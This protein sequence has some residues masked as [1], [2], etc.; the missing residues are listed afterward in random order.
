M[1]ELVLEIMNKKGY[2]PMTIDELYAILN[3]STPEEFTSLAKT[4]NLLVDENLITYNSK[5]EFAPLAYFQMASGIIEVKEAGYAFLDTDEG[6]IYIA[7]NDLKGAITY[8]EVMVKYHLN[9]KKRFEGKVTRIIKRNTQ[10]L[11]GIVCKKHH[12]Y[13]AL[14][15]DPKINLEINISD[16]DLKKVN[17]DDVVRIKITKYF[18]NNTAIGII[19]ENFGNK[20]Q[21]GLDITSLV[22]ASGVSTVFTNE[23]IKEINE[24]PDQINSEELLKNNPKLKDLRKR[25]IVTI[26]GVDAKDLDDAVYVEKL[27]SGNYL[28][29]VYIASVASYVKDGTFLD[30]D[31]LNRGTSIYLPDRVIPMLPT[32]LSNGICS[33][34][35][36]EDRLT[37]ACEMEIDH[38]G[39]VVNYEIFEALINSKH[40]LTYQT[41]NLILEEQDPAFIHILADIYPML[42][43]MQELK[44]I[45]LAK[46]LLRGSFEFTSSEVKVVLDNKQ[47]AIDI[48]V[49]EAKTA[50]KIIEEFMIV[51][52]E[53]VAEAMKWLDV[54]FIYRVHEE[55]NSDKMNRLLLA[56]NQFGYHLK[57]KNQKSL[58]KMLQQ[59]LLDLN[60]NEDLEV[61]KIENDIISKMMIRSMSKAKYQE[62][63]IGHYGLASKCYTHFTSPIRRY[64]DLMVHRLIKQFMLGTSETKKANPVSYFSQIVHMASLQAS[65]LEK[66]AEALER[67]T[68]DLKKIEYLKS[69]LGQTFMGMI[70]SVTNFGMYIT[71]E[72]TIEGLVKYQQ[73]KDDY[74][75]V[76]TLVGKVVGERHHKV[77]QLGDLVKVKVLEANIEKRIVLFAIVGKR[78]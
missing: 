21:P 18:Q 66:K 8:D 47:K 72:N 1:K 14:P 12:Q 25:T 67:D 2:K 70:T 13:V 74:Y 23:T 32:K 63:N 7:P 43:N 45:L 27:A 28:L 51:T 76:D 71:L 24:I 55:P 65:T 64:P 61:K 11:M 16:S 49:K 58:P 75:E 48:I 3:L 6:S 40:R 10:N 20:K 44:E 37:L 57:I 19:E 9:D 26:D 56:L 42:K 69:Y 60:N 15:V 52:N 59:I 30:L 5:G 34:N 62:T 22:L 38:S 41:V 31:A 78:G 73:M 33:L 50:E 36:L 68:T 53:T 46:R 77:Y 17:L 35:P 29:G 54:P 4:L 39:K